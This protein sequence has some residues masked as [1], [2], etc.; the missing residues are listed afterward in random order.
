MVI[1]NEWL[2]QVQEKYPFLATQLRLIYEEQKVDGI[3][4]QMKQVLGKIH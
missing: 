1:T 2:L 4:R 3:V